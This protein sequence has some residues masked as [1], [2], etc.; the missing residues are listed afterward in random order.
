M[1]VKFNIKNEKSWQ[2][3][4]FFCN[5]LLNHKTD[6]KVQKLLLQVKH[7]GLGSL[8]SFAK[9][10]TWISRQWHLQTPLQ[11]LFYGDETK[12]ASREHKISL[13]RPG[14][15][16]FESPG[17]VKY[18][19]PSIKASVIDMYRWGFN[20]VPK[21]ATEII[22]N[23]LPTLGVPSVPRTSVRWCIWQWTPLTLRLWMAEPQ[24]WTSCLIPT[25]SLTIHPQYT[26]NQISSLRPSEYHC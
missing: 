1:C 13:W 4:T 11:M 24:A 23:I 3:L 25:F 22:T 6:F 12:N 26:D 20:R 19:S 9:F 2:D 5:Q 17:S 18:I 8:T 16:E 7:F 10:S 15:R 21:A 14:M